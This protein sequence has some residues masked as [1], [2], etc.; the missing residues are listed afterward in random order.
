MVVKLGV[1]KAETMAALTAGRKVVEMVVVKAV[2]MVA[3]TVV[4]MVAR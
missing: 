1:W 2:A 4:N 3:G